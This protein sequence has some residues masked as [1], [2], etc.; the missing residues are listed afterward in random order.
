MRSLEH[1]DLATDRFTVCSAK[2]EAAIAELDSAEDRRSYL[3]AY[4]IDPHDGRYDGRQEGRYDEGRRGGRCGERS[5]EIGYH[6]GPG[7][8]RRCSRSGGALR[9][10]LA[11]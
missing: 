9:W 7:R 5:G 3:E 8:E 1:T 10:R 2:L 11:M 4:G 6:G